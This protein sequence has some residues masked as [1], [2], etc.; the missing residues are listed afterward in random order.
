MTAQVI[1]AVIVTVLGT[2]LCAL[3]CML[4][5][6]FRFILLADIGSREDNRNGTGRT[7]QQGTGQTVDLRVTWLREFFVLNLAV[8]NMQE[9]TVYL[10]GRRIIRTTPGAGKT[11]AKEDVG[12]SSERVEETYEAVEGSSERVEKIEPSVKDVGAGVEAEAKKVKAEAKK[13]KKAQSAG[14]LD[15][16]RKI[17]SSGDLVRPGVHLVYDIA[18]SFSLERLYCRMSLGFEDREYTGFVAGMNYALVIDSILI[19]KDITSRVLDLLLVVQMTL[20]I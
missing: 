20:F 9:L 6:P 16:V 1:I 10:F 3:L 14:I 15:K 4:F 19:Q 5:V 18:S 7:G 12:E 17:S 2:L 8:F 11:S 13:I